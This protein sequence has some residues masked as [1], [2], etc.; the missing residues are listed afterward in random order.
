[1]KENEEG[2]ADVKLRKQEQFFM[3]LP[4][5]F[6]PFLTILLSSF[7]IVSGNAKKLIT[8]VPAHGINTDL[9][10]AKKS[11]DS[12]WNKLMYYENADRDSA[13]MRSLKE[14]DPYYKAPSVYENI[15]NA[16][17]SGGKFGING[18]KQNDHYSRDENEE[19]VYRK[20]AAIT[21]E[22][23]RNQTKEYPVQVPVVGSR[24]KVDLQGVDRLE[25]MMKEMT[26]DK[27][28]KQMEQISTVLEKILD[29][30]H[31]DR[32]RDRIQEMSETNRSQVFSVRTS[33]NEDVLSIMEPD[34]ESGRSFLDSLRMARYGS[35][36]HFYSLE[37][38]QPEVKQNTIR[39]VIA[40][41]KEVTDGAKVKMR[42]LEDI[43]VAGVLVPRNAY[44]WGKG[45]L[46]EGRFAITVSSIQS[47]NNI[48][49][50]NLTVFD[51][52]GIAG[53]DVNASTETEIVKHSTD[54]A[55]QSLSI[56]SLDPSIGAQAASAGIQAAKSLVGRK[57][58]VVKVNIRSGYDVLLVDNNIKNR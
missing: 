58:K 27:P 5:L 11:A 43:Y 10:N 28:D 14:K 41:S 53:V 44:V 57:L 25:A 6:V 30:Q 3:V 52:D 50:V 56:G 22:L 7:G 2:V 40:E 49:P 38:Q 1:M 48:L 16:D 15:F 42:L 26:D 8:E 18:M 54:Q 51:I 37:D 20:I 47:G 45:R 33:G 4:V 31:P 32:V 55:I 21:G 46:G 34:K 39:A 9:P 12:S 19:K 36:N 29:I 17:T 35:I 24:D 23:N 13:K